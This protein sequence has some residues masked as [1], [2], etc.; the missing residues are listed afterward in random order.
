MPSLQKSLQ[1]SSLL[2]SFR[3]KHEKQVK[4]AQEQM[5]KLHELEDTLEKL[6]EQIRILESDKKNLEISLKDEVG[7][8]KDAEYA[9]ERTQEQLTRKTEEFNQ[10]EEQYTE[11]MGRIDELSRIQDG[12]G[13]YFKTFVWLYKRICIRVLQKHP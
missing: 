11:A 12:D 10:L 3:S 7:R 5:A 1:N 13:F 4:L 2:D 8:R 9:L 6:N